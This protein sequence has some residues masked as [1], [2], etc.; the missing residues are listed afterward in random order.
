MI[1]VICLT[2]GEPETPNL[3]HQ[4]SYSYSILKR[5]TRLI[6]SIP[7]PIVPIIAAK[8]AW[9][10]NRDQKRRGFHSPLEPISHKFVEDLGH[11]LKMMFPDTVFRVQL[12]LEFRKPDFLDLLKTLV[13]SQTKDLLVVPLY[14]A[15]SSFTSG[16]SKMD[17]Q[18][19]RNQDPGP[20][21][22]AQW[23]SCPNG[24]PEF[25]DL[26][27]EH[28]VAEC[29][30]KGLEGETLSE[31]H[32]VLGAHGT[33]VKPPSGIDNGLKAT[34]AHMDALKQRLDYLF[35]S[36][37]LGW[38]NHVRGGTWTEPAMGKLGKT[39]KLAGH[40]K[41]IYYPIGFL[42]DNA[43]TLL[44]GPDALGDFQGLISLPCLNN[45]LGLVDYVAQKI[46]LITGLVVSEK[47][48][49]TKVEANK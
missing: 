2:Y 44:E 20:E 23:V 22:K 16:I 5:L 1:E 25:A 7:K 45:S 49:N 37:E 47:S 21:F 31:Y 42:A 26:A 10:R 14:I 24:D 13:P 4:F 41:V 46:G 29:R 11:Q 32:L 40:E 18:L 43:E 33:L 38:L 27:A 15:D 6:D 39:L 35:A 48:V 19:F 9:G 30:K 36:V 8:R 12:G 28:I 34:L 17:W 3:L